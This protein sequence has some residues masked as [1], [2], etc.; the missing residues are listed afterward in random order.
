MIDFL[1]G[2]VMMACAAS[3]LFFFKSWKESHDRL[4]LLFALAFW[5]LAIERWV[6]VFVLPANE[7]RFY[8]YT[9]RLTAF[10]LIATAIV[11]KNRS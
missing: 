7:F 5:V 6:L 9:L 11:H 4:F 1:S 3:G 8:V 2:A 10:V